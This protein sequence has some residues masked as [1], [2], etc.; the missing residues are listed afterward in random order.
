MEEYI[1]KGKKGEVLDRITNIDQEGGVSIATIHTSGD[2][3]IEYQGK[4]VL[5]W[6]K[7]LVTESAI[8]PSVIVA[9]YVATDTYRTPVGNRAVKCAGLLRQERDE[10]E[11]IIR[12][13][14]FQGPINF[15]L[16]AE[17]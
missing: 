7:A 12:K 13:Q 14:G 16:K 2:A 17:N 15:N 9:G 6:Q 4:R 1:L 10:L 11:Q 5:L 3:F 8:I